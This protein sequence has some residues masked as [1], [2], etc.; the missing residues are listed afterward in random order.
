D[1]RLVAVT[2]LS[3]DIAF[4][5]LMLPLAVGA[6]VVV[7]T[8]DEV[9]DGAALRQLVETTSAT[10]LQA[11]PAGWRL[12][13]DA[14]WQGRP[15][16]VAVSGGEPLTRDL[17]EALLAR[18]GTVWNAYGPTECT[19]WSTFWKVANPARGITIGR[20]LPGTT[21]WVLDAANRPCPPGISGEL[22]IGGAGVADGYLRRPALTAERFVADPFSTAPGARLYRTGDRGR[23]NAHGLLE[24]QGRADFQIK[25]RGYRIEP[26]EIE[27]RLVAGPGVAQAVVVAREARPGDVRLVAY[28]AAQDGAAINE[29]AVRERLHGQLP[30][31]MVPQHVVVLAALPRLPNGKL[32][33]ARLPTPAVAT[34]SINARPADD[35]P[36][37]DIEHEL[38]RMMADVLG[39]PCGRTEDF[40]AAGGHSLLAAQFIARVN[41]ACD[42]R[43][44]L[45]TMFEAP[46][47]ARLAEGIRRARQGGADAV[48]PIARRADRVFAPLTSMQQRVW[49]VEQMHPGSVAWNTP[50]AHRLRGDMDVAA[51][52]RALQAIV[53]R[54]SVLRTGIE[55]GADGVRQRVSPQLDVRLPLEDLSQLPAATREAQLQARLDALIEAP[56]DLAVAPLF[57][58]RLF[59]LAPQEHVFFFMAHHVI[60]DGWSFDLLYQEMAALYAAFAV[61]KPDPLPPLAVEYGDFAVWH[62]ARFAGAARER[63]LAPWLARLANPPAPLALPAD[64]P[65]PPRMSG[66]AATEWIRVGAA[67]LRAVHALADRLG[68]TAFVVLL[69][70][71]AALLQRLSGQ[72]DFVVSTPVRNRD[73]IELERVMGFFVNALPL[74]LMPQAGESFAQLVA[75]TRQA[76]LDAF[77]SPDLPFEDLVR[78]LH[79]PH[80]ESR[81]PLAQAM[82]SFQDVRGRVTTWGGLQHEH[83]PVFQHGGAEDLGLWFVEQADGLLG[84]LSFNTDIFEPAT[85]QRFHA[86]YTAL[87][88]SA[89]ATPDAA[90]A[91]L[92]M[93]AVAATVTA[94]AAP[95]ASTPEDARNESDVPRGMSVEETRLAAIWCALIGVAEARPEDNFFDLGGH[96]LLAIEM[97]TRVQREFGV[98]LNLIDI[99][100]GT[101]ATL[102][103]SLPTQPVARVGLGGRIR[104]W[105]GRP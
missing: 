24:H 48:A 81:P 87:L 15:D 80:D 22:W 29:A 2:T 60:W 95:A 96:S 55:M 17:A 45:R 94:P 32:D 16:F 10:F 74:R 40:F 12:L 63:Q 92:P 47:V 59:R 50:S 82:F 9:R 52:E 90:L 99:A 27:A 64:R 6:S 78:A 11:T 103:A 89:L 36:C 25:V 56:F 38:A 86:G 34:P 44:T 42:T 57:R 26:G 77:A 98:R 21:A 46:T 58:A 54:Q 53:Q 102:A 23:W 20:P 97:A 35:T 68:T 62:R 14:G 75:A 88:A 3:F 1:D 65:R 39:H 104:H 84:G 28:V 51:F 93:A 19:V 79:L 61:G 31:Y 105:F 72:S 4:L 76:V 100:T 13:L 69:A 37:D 5:E 30:D 49:Y 83:L 7:A 41:R 43:L 18:C 70:A 33:R 101:L 71:F 91:D 85:A 66:Q 8:R 73:E 67:P